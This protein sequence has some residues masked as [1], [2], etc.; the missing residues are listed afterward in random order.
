[1]LSLE[2]STAQIRKGEPFQILLRISSPA[3]IEVVQISWTL[4][5]GFDLAWKNAIELPRVFQNGSSFTATFEVTPPGSKPF[6]AGSDTREKKIFTFNVDYIENGQR[7]AEDA[8]FSLDFSLNPLIYLLTGVVGLIFGGVLKTVASSRGQIT[9]A[10]DSTHLVQVLTSVA[11]GFVALLV[12]ARDKIPTKGWYD[13]FAL[14]VSLAFLSDEQLLTKV[15]GN[16]SG[17]PL[18]MNGSSISS[19]F[20][21]CSFILPAS[22]SVRL[23]N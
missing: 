5:N 10:V 3:T 15:R 2:S 11:I 13:S 12:L 20:F 14:G 22:W 4:P 6:T 8:R 1:M 7:K 9:A 19:F 17:A 18:G 21:G 16:H 23:L